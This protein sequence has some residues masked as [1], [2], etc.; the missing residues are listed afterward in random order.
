MPNIRVTIMILLIFTSCSCVHTSFSVNPVTQTLQ[1]FYNGIFS[2]LGLGPVTDV[3]SCYNTTTA[4]TQYQFF[5]FWAIDISK[6]GEANAEIATWQY[7]NSTGGQLYL[8]LPLSTLN[9]RKSSQDY[10]R[11]CEALGID[12]VETEF[13]DEFQIYISTQTE[14]Y[15]TQF[16]NMS[17]FFDTLSPQSA[18]NVFGSFLQSVT[19]EN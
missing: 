16:H 5:Y 10:A 1:D 6:A 15:Y 8:E 4:A 11:F 3:M 19:Q 12:P 9:C 18:G 14:S 7:F 13:L 2:Q 17:N